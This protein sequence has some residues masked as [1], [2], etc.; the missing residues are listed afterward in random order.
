MEQIKQALGTLAL[1][2]AKNWVHI[3]RPQ[4]TSLAVVA[5]MV[6]T[7]IGAGIVGI[8]YVFAAAGFLTGTLVLV[9]VGLAIML[10]LLFMG[11]VTLRTRAQHQL[12][13]YAQLYLG[14]WARHLQTL[15][16][17]GSI[18]GALLAYTI[19][20]GEILGTA[21]GGSHLAWGLAFYAVFAW[22]VSR[23]IRTVRD[24]EMIML[25]VILLAI[26]LMA[27]VAS[28]QIDVAYLADF[29]WSKLL[30]PYG[31]VLF[32]CSGVAAIPQVREVVGF[33]K[34][35]QDLLKWIIIGALFPIVAYFIFALTVVGLTGPATTEVA[36]LGL[37]ALGFTRL[38]GFI[39]L[40]LLFTMATS[41]LSLGLAAKQ[42]YTYDL[43]LSRWWAVLLVFG[44]PLLLLLGGARGFVDILSFVG[45]VGVGIIGMLTVLMF[46]RA[47]RLGDRQPEYVLPGFVA[48]G[49]GSL[50]FV[51]FA[52]GAIWA[53]SHL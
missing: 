14:R 22:L 44:P 42:V 37:G 29:N 49:L 9:V 47:R 23:G 35:E 30:I 50:V 11:E 25:P 40:L 26:V 28:G 52:V 38:A 19:G 10:E 5:L 46:W 8:P 39:S 7:I 34:S 2:W 16:L 48:Y 18:W 20:I 31:V 43:K 12:P 6:G 41:F 4:L 13:G 36:S 17:I 51:M 1:P 45:A 53:I 21:F 15:V 3:R 33:A 32:A 27:V 24:V